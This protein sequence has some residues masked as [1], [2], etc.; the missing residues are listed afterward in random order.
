MSRVRTVAVCAVVGFLLAAVWYFWPVISSPECAPLM[1]RNSS[2]EI[3][4]GCSE[5]ANV[6]D[7]SLKVQFARER[8]QRGVVFRKWIVCKVADS[9]EGPT[10]AFTRNRRWMETYVPTAFQF[11]RTAVIFLPGSVNGRSDVF[12]EVCEMPWRRYA[13]LVSGECHGKFAAWE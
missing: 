11:R 2:V 4:P 8:E 10:L 3:P 9:I 7:D 6:G 1:F 5:V 13:Q 12:A